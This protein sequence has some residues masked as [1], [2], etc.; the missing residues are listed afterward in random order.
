MSLPRSLDGGVPGSG[1]PRKTNA[2]CQNDTILLLSRSRLSASHR[3]VGSRNG[4]ETHSTV[5]LVG[6]H[7]HACLRPADPGKPQCPRDHALAEEVASCAEV[8]RKPQGAVLADLVVAHARWRRFPLPW[9]CSSPS[10]CPLSA[11]NPLTTSPP[12]IV[13]LCQSAGASVCDATDFGSAPA[14]PCACR[15]CPVGTSLTGRPASAP[16]PRPLLRDARGHEGRRGRR[17]Q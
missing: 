16:A 1:P 17:S 8:H 3:R 13:E 5:G 2:G 9:T 11:R 6:R 4:P 14:G 7:H 12:R 10:G 15:C